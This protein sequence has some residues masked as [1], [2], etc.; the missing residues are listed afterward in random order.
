MLGILLV[1]IKEHKI[2]TYAEDY[3]PC[4]Y[5]A[6]VYIKQNLSMELS[7]SEAEQLLV[8]SSISIKDLGQKFGYSDQLYF[9]RRFKEKFGKSPQEYR[10][11]QHI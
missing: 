11:E 3:S 8:S 4:I 7:I 9:S 1:F 5:K 6:L 2:S 10:K